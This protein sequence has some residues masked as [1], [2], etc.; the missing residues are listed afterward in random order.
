MAEPLIGPLQNLDLSGIHQIVVGGESVQYLKDRPKLRLPDP[1]W[2][3]GLRD[4][5]LESD[6]P[7]MFKQWGGA[8]KEREANGCVLD[9]E[10][11]RQWPEKIRRWH[12]ARGYEY[13][14]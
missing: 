3:R 6:V 9:G 1:E 11:W 13:R 5:C 14:T 12:E 7:F 10:V 2:I 8:G 4:Q